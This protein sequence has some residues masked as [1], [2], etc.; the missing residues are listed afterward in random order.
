MNEPCQN[1]CW[2]DAGKLIATLPPIPVYICCWCG[3]EKAA[4]EIVPKAHGPHKPVTYELHDH[5]WRP[6]ATA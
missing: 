1:H 3:Q 4:T 6:E 2:H 5:Y